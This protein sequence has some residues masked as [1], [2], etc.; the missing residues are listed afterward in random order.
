MTRR[1][2]VFTYDQNRSPSK[3]RNVNESK[4]VMVKSACYEKIS[5]Q[6]FKSNVN[7][8]LYKYHTGLTEKIS[9]S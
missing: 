9:G 1:V 8:F 6:F 4:Y 2:N 7:I 3:V 5:S